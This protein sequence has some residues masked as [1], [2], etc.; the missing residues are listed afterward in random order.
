MRV[1]NEHLVKSVVNLTTVCSG[2]TEDRVGRVA[3]C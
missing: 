2:S 3:T 1:F